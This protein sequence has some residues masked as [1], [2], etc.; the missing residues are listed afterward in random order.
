MPRKPASPP[1]RKRRSTTQAKRNTGRS[2]PGWL[3]LVTGVAVGVFAFWIYHLDQQGS[4]EPAEEPKTAEPAPPAA[5]PEPEPE[6]RFRFR[7]L[8]L[9]DEVAVPDQTLPP[10]RRDDPAA[11]QPAPTVE[12]GYIYVL[13]AGSFRSHDDAD[14][15]RATLTLLGLEARI[16]SV[17]L[18]D[19]TRWHRVRVGPFD[20][21][22]ELQRAHSRLE[23]NNIQ[24]LLLRQR[25]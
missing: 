5:E 12:E 22:E 23:E 2:L 18:D 25:G 24:P 3:W 8:L 11:P 17:D 13:Q 9:E 7:E 4:E 10:R 15:L 20:D 14:G 19:G 1:P 21:T 16:H 6:R